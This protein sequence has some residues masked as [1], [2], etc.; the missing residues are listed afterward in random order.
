MKELKTMSRLVA[1]RDK[2]NYLIGWFDDDVDAQSF[3]KRNDP[4]GNKGFH[5]VKT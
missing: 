3:I 2:G 4:H 1:V 5:I